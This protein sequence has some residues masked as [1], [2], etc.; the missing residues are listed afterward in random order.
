MA[1]GKFITLE[2]GE[3]VGK[4]TL[5]RRLAEKLAK[6]RIDVVVTREPGG[7]PGAELLRDILLNGDV[8][9]WSARTEALLMFA[10]RVDHVER[11]IKPALAC[12]AWVL[13]DRFADSTRAYQGVAGGLSASDLA[14]L[15]HFALGDFNADLT[16]VVDLDPA[17]G[18]ER[19][20]ERGE[21]ATRFEKFDTAYHQRLRQAFLDIAAEAPQRC[22][23]LD[24]AS[25]PDQLLDAAMTAID[26][27]L[28]ATT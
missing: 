12:G 25:T 19:T 26:T 10:A 17:T 8:K 27:R 13:C 20:V 16:L 24:G 22:A 5:I 7:T 11:R 15:Q 14:E 3:G 4:T 6:R 21:K 23:V 28:I 9:R 18:L 1:A 2:G